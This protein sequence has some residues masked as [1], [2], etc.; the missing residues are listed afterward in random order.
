MIYEQVGHGK[1]ND[2]QSRPHLRRSLD[3]LTAVK[4]KADPEQKIATVDKVV[5]FS[6]SLLPLMINKLVLKI[7][8]LLVALVL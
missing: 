4:R 2:P 6:R 3:V 8:S 7:N 5:D 1:V